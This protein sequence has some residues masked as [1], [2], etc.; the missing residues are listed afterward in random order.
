MLQIGTSEKTGP[1]VWQPPSY[2]SPSCSSSLEGATL[3]TTST[4]VWK[5]MTTTFPS[6]SHDMLQSD[7]N[8]FN[9]SSHVFARHAKIN[10][11]HVWPQQCIIGWNESTPIL[12]SGFDKTS[13]RE[14]SG[15]GASLLLYLHLHPTGACT[16]LKRMAVVWYMAINIWNLTYKFHGCWLFVTWAHVRSIFCGSKHPNYIYRGVKGRGC[17]HYAV[18]PKTLEILIAL[19]YHHQ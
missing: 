17:W 4:R 19:F 16:L 10:F 3:W 13:L 8:N 15:C 9:T 11:Q 14:K 5:Y 7:W 18:G 2:A 6:L 12:E 1:G